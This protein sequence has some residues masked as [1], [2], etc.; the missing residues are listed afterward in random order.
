MLPAARL[1]SKELCTR[2]VVRRALRILASW[3]GTA[4]GTLSSCDHHQRGA[5]GASK[6][7]QIKQNTQSVVPFGSGLLSV[8]LS[9][10][11]P[12]RLRP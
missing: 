7:E 8:E 11:A 5:T 4:R 9:L 2:R 12:S 6:L 10:C 1:H 3:P